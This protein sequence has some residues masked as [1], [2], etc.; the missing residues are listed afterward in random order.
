MKEILNKVFNNQYLNSEEIRYIVEL[1]DSNEFIPEQMSALIAS[2]TTRNIS[3]DELA[4]FAKYIKLKAKNINISENINFLDVCGTGGDCLSTFNIST[5]VSFVLAA[6]GIK[7]AKHGNRSVSSKC[8]CAD[9][10]EELG[11]NINPEFNQLSNIL[12]KTNLL[13]FLAPVYNPILSSIKKIRNSIQAPT[14]FNL[15]GP[16]V[17]PVKLDYQI[18]GVYDE[19]KCELIANTLLKMGVKEAMVVHSM[20]GLDELSIT[21]DNLIYHLKNNK[22][23][24]IQSPNLNEIGLKPASIQD[25]KGVDRKLN[26]KIIL[27][28]LNGEKS[29]KRDIVLLNSAAALIVSNVVKDF[30]E[31]TKL[32]ADLIDSKKALNVLKELQ[33]VS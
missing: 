25:I 26:A 28:I 4:N 3:P 16:L 21:S 7:V 5:V 13:F 6:A 14:I 10:L 27:D 11:V 31:G 33:N 29:A 1:I 24:K 8:G 2:V 23:K 22:I 19:T 30:K 17:N 32:A 12:E 18:I 9:V 15:L 20:D